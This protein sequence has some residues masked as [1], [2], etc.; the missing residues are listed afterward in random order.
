[1]PLTVEN[2]T[3]WDGRDLRRLCRR[4]VKHTDGHL[5]RTVTIK[6]SKSRG[7]ETLWDMGDRHTDEECR[8]GTVRNLYRGRASLG[9]RRK[10]Y[11]GVPKPERKVDGR[12]LRHEFDP[13]M[14]ARVL[15]H[16]IR[17]NQGLRHGDMT[18]DVRYC[19]QDIDYDLS[20][21]EVT[22]KPSY[23]FRTDPQ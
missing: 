4:V 5:N 12:W 2:H 15:E 14:F 7:K 21:I 11:M 17:H 3:D 6:T 20:D 8:V 1:M 19:R 10:L 13:R 23:E 18:D 22:P 16:E 9:S